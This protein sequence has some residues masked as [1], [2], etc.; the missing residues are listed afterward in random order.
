MAGVVLAAGAGRRLA[1]LTLLRPK[2]L[3]PVGSVPLVDLAI[4]RLR[5]HV[6]QVAVNVHHGRAG[7]Q[8]H[9][10]D[11]AHVSVEE[12]EALGTAGALGRLKGWVDGRPVLLTNADAWLPADLG[13][14][15]TGWDGERIRLLVVDDPLRGD[16]GRFRYC[17]AALF[18]WSALRDLEP[19]PSGLYEMRWR[20]A[21]EAGALDLVTHRGPFIDCGSP[22]EY[23]AANLAASGGTSVVSPDARVQAGAVL[24][25]SVVWPDSVVRSQ[26][27]LVDA[28]RA[29]PITVLVR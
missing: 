4:D 25:R 21:W 7:L 16:F 2:A 9:L 10:G 27:V 28:I 14:L 1:P 17:G 6:A 5:P 20:A 23:L 13:L 22:A 15:I 11:R 3:C 26:E 29:G 24:T 18:P 12:P 8:A 19:V